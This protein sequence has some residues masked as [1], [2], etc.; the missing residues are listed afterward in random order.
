MAKR[1]R[2]NRFDVEWHYAGEC[3]DRISAGLE[4]NPIP[5][6]SIWESDEGNGKEI[7]IGNRPISPKRVT[8]NGIT[9]FE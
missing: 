6:Y 5:T 3:W 7:L 4:I 9:V 8:C 1:I 2:N